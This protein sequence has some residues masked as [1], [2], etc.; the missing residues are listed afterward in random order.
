M[1]I[2]KIRNKNEF[3]KLVTIIKDNNLPNK[4]SGGYVATSNGS[5]EVVRLPGT[6]YVWVEDIYGNIK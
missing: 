1:A 6:T 4:N 2:F 5:I 3:D